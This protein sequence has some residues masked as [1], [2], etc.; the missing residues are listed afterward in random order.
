MPLVPHFAKLEKMTD[1]ELRAAYDKIADVGNVNVGVTFLL[2]EIRRR[3]AARETR[4]MVR[5]TWAIFA[6][7]AIVTLATL[8]MLVLT[9]AGGAAPVVGSLPSVAP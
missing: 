8:A 9:W 6:F 1:E 5:L 4:T 3:E 2:D 7:T